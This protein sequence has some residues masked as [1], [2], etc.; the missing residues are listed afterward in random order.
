MLKIIEYNMD[1]ILITVVTLVF[2]IGLGYLI[3][4]DMNH[5]AERA[6]V[7]I[8]VGNQYINGDCVK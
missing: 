2:M 1:V 3:T 4:T 8:E 6:I 7:C 5:D